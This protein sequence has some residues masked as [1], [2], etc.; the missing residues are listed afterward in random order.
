MNVI[1][2]AWL[3]LLLLLPACFFLW[4]GAKWFRRRRAHMHSIDRDIQNYAVAMLVQELES[5]IGFSDDSSL[6]DVQTCE[7]RL[8]GNSTAI[9]AYRELIKQR[10]RDDLTDLTKTQ[11]DRMAGILRALWEREHGEDSIHQRAFGKG[12][13]QIERP[14]KLR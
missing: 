10:D 8:H 13:A 9:A 2:W 4:R 7:P 12:A 5:C 6:S 3:F 11:S 14:S 1:P